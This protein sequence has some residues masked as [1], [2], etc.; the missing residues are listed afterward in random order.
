MTWEGCVVKLSDKIAY[1][2]RDIEDAIQLGFID[3]EAKHTLKKWHR[4][5]I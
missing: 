1:V 3:D 5:T 2:G 4:Q